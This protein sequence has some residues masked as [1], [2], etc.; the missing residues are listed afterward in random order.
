MDMADALTLSHENSLVVFEFRNTDPKNPEP[1]KLYA[2]TKLLSRKC[3]YYETSTPFLSP[4][5]VFNSAFQEGDIA[6]TTT[7]V[8]NISATPLGRHIRVKDD[9]NL[10]HSVLYYI[11]SDCI[12]FSTEPSRPDN[13]CNA[14]EIYSIADRLLLDDLKE[15]GSCISCKDLYR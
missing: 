9:Y 13:F 6:V 4:N 5:I 3:K 12:S 1:K 14:E 15:K 8:A 2:H 10:L 7:N 11:Y